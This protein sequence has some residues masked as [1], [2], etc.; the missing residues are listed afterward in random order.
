[1]KF[2]G[3]SF[4][5][6][7]RASIPKSWDRFVKELEKYKDYEKRCPRRKKKRRLLRTSQAMENQLFIFFRK[8]KYKKQLL[9]QI[10]Y[11]SILK[12]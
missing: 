12:N 1:M 5:F 9:Q 4:F 3:V 11:S 2:L 7:S 10:T 8:E 6:P